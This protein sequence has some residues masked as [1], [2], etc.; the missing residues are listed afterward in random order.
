MNFWRNGFK[1]TTYP[2]IPTDVNNNIVLPFDGE[3]HGAVAGP[4][5]ADLCDG[6]GVGHEVDEGHVPIVLTHLRQGE[7]DAGEDQVEKVPARQADHQTMEDVLYRF[8]K[9]NWKQTCYQ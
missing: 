6:H 1:E 9:M 5:E 2:E 4:G 8:K 3:S 7:A